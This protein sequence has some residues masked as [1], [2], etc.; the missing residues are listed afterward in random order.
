MVAAA[1]A[2]RIRALTSEIRKINQRGLIA[3]ERTRFLSGD[4]EPVVPSADGDETAKLMVHFARPDTVFGV[5]A[6]EVMCELLHRRGVGGATALAGV[7]GTAAG[8]RQRGRFVGRNADV[9]MMVVVVGA[10]KLIRAVLPEL[11]DLLRSP[12]MTLSRVQVCK[13]DSELISPPDLPPPND[14][15]GHSVGQKL[16]VFA[17]AATQH[18]GQPL[19]RVLI[20]RLLTA[21]IGGATTQTGVWGFRGDHVPHGGQHFRSLG[22]HVPAVTVLVDVPQRIAAAFAVIDEL[23]GEHGLVTCENVTIMAPVE[24]E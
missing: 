6:F 18:Q 19:H 7:D 13:R 2:P 16:T 8:H 3:V 17:S 1:A 20:R 9:P 15:D 22:Q 5:P 14:D 23:T 11:G 10:G 24:S 12:R 21:G 4:I